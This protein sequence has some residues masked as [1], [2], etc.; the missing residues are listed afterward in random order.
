M[1]HQWKALPERAS[2]IFERGGKKTAVINE[3]RV[4]SL[5]ANIV[6]LAVI[7]DFCPKSSSRG[8]ASDARDD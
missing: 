3:E 2:E 1:I 5:H 8:L 7:N 4:R 6:E